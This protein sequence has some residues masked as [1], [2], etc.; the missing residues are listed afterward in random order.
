[1]NVGRLLRCTASAR[2]FSAAEALR[3]EPSRPH[4]LPHQQSRYENYDKT[5]TT[6]DNVRS[7]IGLPD[8]ESVLS[9]VASRR[10]LASPRDLSCLDG[11]CG[12]GNY[13]H[14]LS[15]VVGQVTGV[16]PNEGMRAKARAKMA[17]AGVGNVE[18]LD[19]SL[20]QLPVRDASVDVVWITQVLHHL[21]DSS[22]T[23]RYGRRVRVYAIVGCPA[24][25][26]AH[27]FMPMP[28]SSASSQPS[29]RFISGADL[30]AA[31]PLQ[32]T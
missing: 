14:S 10:G 2:C 7:P 30:S 1:M 15:K 4:S 32:C 20:D 24:L 13:T 8:F 9:A 28:P 22:T 16:E 19:G 11:G 23:P 3:R 5:S 31:P 12:T 18:V 27:R 26:L 21:Y 17:G 25:E 6:Y 29:G